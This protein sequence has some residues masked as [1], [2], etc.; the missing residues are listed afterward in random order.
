MGE[1]GDV[2]YRE[3]RTDKHTVVLL[4]RL[5]VGDGKRFREFLGFVVLTVPQGLASKREATV[6]PQQPLSGILVLL[7]LLVIYQ[8]FECAREV[9]C[10]VIS[11]AN[12]LFREMR[13]L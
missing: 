13:R 8:L 1:K 4:Q 9:G 11:G 2:A 7:A 12:F 6:Q 5:F 10:S 3:N